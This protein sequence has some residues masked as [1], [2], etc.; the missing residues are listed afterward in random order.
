MSETHDLG[1]EYMNFLCW[2]FYEHLPAANYN[3][4]EIISFPANYYLFVGQMTWTCMAS[5]IVQ[6]QTKI[7][8]LILHAIPKHVRYGFLYPEVWFLNS[9]FSKDLF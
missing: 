6:S 4:E 3:A 1:I 2:A 8:I 9:K 7:S 5:C